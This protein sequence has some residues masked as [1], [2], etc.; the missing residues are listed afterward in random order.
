MI[1]SKSKSYQILWGTALL[2]IFLQSFSVKS[3]TQS[4]PHA[5]SSDPDFITKL[6]IQTSC[7][8]LWSRLYNETSDPGLM[9]RPLISR[10]CVAFV[11]H[12]S[13]PMP[14]RNCNRYYY[15]LP[16]LFVPLF[17]CALICLCARLLVRSDYT[18]WNASDPRSNSPSGESRIHMWPFIKTLRSF[19]WI[20]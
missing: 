2:F 4:R 10:W 7:L 5:Q 13:H 8:N 19:R 1:G 15:L 14:S 11:T 6:L 12:A 18:L 3:L 16:A 9:I 17:V 20:I